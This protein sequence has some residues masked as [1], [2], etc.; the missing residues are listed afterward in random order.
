[1][2]VTAEKLPWEELEQEV[3]QVGLWEQPNVHPY[4]D[5]TIE[6]REF[7]FHEVRPTSLY[8]ISANLARQR[9]LTEALKSFAIDPLAL[10]GKVILKDATGGAVGLIPPIVEETP[11]DGKYIL[12]GLH[13]TYSGKM[14]GRLTF[15]GIYITGIIPE[16]PAA[17]R[18]NNW[19][20][21]KVWDSTPPLASQKRRYRQE[22]Y[23][24]LRRDFSAINGS[25]PRMA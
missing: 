1:M 8:V 10:K 20:D 6:L 24:A 7:A 25:L 21:I 15:W 12:D 5:A 9:E 4:A 3:R 23:L 16:Y 18:P 22:N 19:E 11:E 13:R 14:I 17:A 2:F